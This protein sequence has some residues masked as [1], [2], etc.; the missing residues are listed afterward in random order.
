MSELSIVQWYGEHLA[1]ML[2][3]GKSVSIQG[4][5]VGAF[6]KRFN[7]LKKPLQATFTE[8]HRGDVSAEVRLIPES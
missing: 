7:L 2:R 1:N 6:A 8:D 5:E 4:H 3:D